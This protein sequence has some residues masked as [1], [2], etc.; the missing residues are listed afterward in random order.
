MAVLNITSLT[1]C[2]S[3]PDFIATG[4]LMVFQ[5]TSAPLNWTKQITHNDKALRVISGTATPGGSVSFSTAFASQPVAGS[6]SV[7]GTVGN[8]TLT[9]NEMPIHAHPQGAVNV[10]PTLNIYTPTPSNPPVNAQTRAAQTTT[11]NAGSGAA[12]AHPFSG[13][14]TFTGTNID[15]TVQYV[16]VIIAS[17]D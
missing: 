5:Q 13:S 16:D 14:A 17:K 12:H 9:T 15:L 3:I 1:G 10:A 7:S 11:G 6:V 2:S 4:T 8:F